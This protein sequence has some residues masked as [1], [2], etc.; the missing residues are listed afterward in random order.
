[1][2]YA[3]WCKH[4]KQLEPEYEGAAAE[5]VEWGVR[6]AKVDGTKE[7][8]LADQYSI[9]GWPALKMFRKGRVYEY[10]GPR[11]KDN[12]V[13]FMREQF[14]PPSEQKDHMLGLTNNMDRLDITVVGFFK[15][16]TDLY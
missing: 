4:C 3:P 2:F 14:K 5:L 8:E 15:G 1:M 11:E 7:K 16:K 12:I 9:P 6:L 10:N 13:T